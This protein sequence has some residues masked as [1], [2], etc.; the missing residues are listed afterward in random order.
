MTR[1]MLQVKTRKTR[2]MKRKSVARKSRVTSCGEGRGD[3]TEGEQELA[4][5]GQ[6]VGG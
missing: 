4:D 3:G 6:V 5:E 1:R 2:L